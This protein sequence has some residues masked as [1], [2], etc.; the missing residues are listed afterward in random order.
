MHELRGKNSRGKGVVIS[1]AVLASILLFSF[2]PTGSAVGAME[3]GA[4][5]YRD[6][7]NQDVFQ[8][9]SWTRSDASVS[10]NTTE[11]LLHIGHD[12]SWDDYAR[13][14]VSFKLP[15][16]IEA[17]MRLVSDGRNYTLPALHVYFG[18]DEENIYVTYLSDPA[19]GWAL[20]REQD[21]PSPVYNGEHDRA[22]AAGVEWSTVKVIIRQ[23]GGE[24]QVKRQTDPDFQTVASRN[25]S[26][27]LPYT[28]T[29]IK[30]RQPWD[31]VIDVDYVDVKCGMGGRA[32]EPF[33]NL[34]SSLRSHLRDAAWPCTE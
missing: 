11:G 8:D 4:F 30:F 26:T 16:V 7:F 13:T 15:V 23:D 21:Q 19:A 5:G 1:V 6:D 28:M 34:V 9:G 24:L 17:R 27:Q 29:A 3:R 31:A 25:W 22:P 12:W 14:D 20:G 2:L 18:S 10:V 33:E 32:P